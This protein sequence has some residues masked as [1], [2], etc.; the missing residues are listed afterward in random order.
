MALELDIVS[1]DGSIFKGLVDMVL[2]PASTGDV[3]ILA[4][5][6]PY[7]TAL[8]TGV[9]LTYDKG[10]I[11]KKFFVT[12]GFAEVNKDMVTLLVTSVADLDNLNAKDIEMEI[13]QLK[14]D[15]RLSKSDDEKNLLQEL[16]QIADKK[17]IALEQKIYH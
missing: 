5:H 15:L 4:G 1:P 2:L 7:V 6:A 14:E 3:G 11:T 9:C 16:L 12:S 13:S 8:R 10:K 17:L